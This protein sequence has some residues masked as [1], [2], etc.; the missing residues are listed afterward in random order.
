[1]R[2]NVLQFVLK[3]SVRL[4][5]PLLFTRSSHRSQF[6]LITAFRCGSRRYANRIRMDEFE[7][8]TQKK[9]YTVPGNVECTTI[10]FGADTFN[11][12]FVVE[13]N[14]CDFHI[15]LEFDFFLSK[16]EIFS[17]IFSSLQNI[18]SP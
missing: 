8:R 18:F 15:F 5:C 9:G 4:F 17:K 14:F 13:A 16:I 1:M 12:F 10:G 2:S 7:R 11:D 3:C 6:S